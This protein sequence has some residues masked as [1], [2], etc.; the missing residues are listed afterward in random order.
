MAAW[1]G[2]SGLAHSVTARKTW[3]VCGARNMK[4]IALILGLTWL[5]AELGSKLEPTLQGLV[6]S[7]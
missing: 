6:P 5:E 7:S 3:G 2:G 4:K 1:G